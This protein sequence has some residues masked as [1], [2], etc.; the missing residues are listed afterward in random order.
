ML[1]LLLL[2]LPSEFLKHDESC[3]WGCSLKEYTDMTETLQIQCGS[4][5]HRDHRV[6]SCVERPDEIWMKRWNKYDVQ[7]VTPCFLYVI[8]VIEWLRRHNQLL[9][10]TCSRRDYSCFVFLEGFSGQN[11]YDL[12]LQWQRWFNLLSSDHGFLQD[13]EQDISS[14][15]FFAIRNINALWRWRIVIESISTWLVLKHKA[16]VS[17]GSKC[18]LTL[19]WTPDADSRCHLD[20]AEACSA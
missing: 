11:L 1:S 7:N 18:L 6:R 12:D 14:L 2:F 3:A 15:S 20:C 9:L 19:N 4:Q 17:R 16:G 5:N 8:L 10:S 13:W